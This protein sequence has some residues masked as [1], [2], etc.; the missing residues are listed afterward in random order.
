MILCN[1]IRKIRKEV[2][3]A[4]SRGMTIGLVPT[5][6]F[7]HEGHLH[8]VDMIRQYADFVIV[9]IYVNPTQFEPNEDLDTYPRDRDGDFEKLK[10]RH[11]DAVF[12]PDDEI[13]YP[14]PYYSYV[15]VEDIANIL[16]GASRPGHFRGVTTIV[17]KL[18]NIIQP[19]FA[20]FGEKDFQQLA[21][22]EKMT[23]DLNMPVKIIGAPIM[24]ESD[25][26]A[27]S[28]RNKY[29]ND[30][31]R[32]EATILYRSLQL[33]K[34]IFEKGETETKTIMQQMRD[35]IEANSSGKI[36]YIEFFDAKT[37]TLKNKAD[38]YTRVA[39]A[40]YFGKTRLIDNTPIKTKDRHE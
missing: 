40:V 13:M 29:L 11:V 22:I 19:G 20:V 15:V 36:D 9:S 10:K 34:N 23:T 37:L 2:D 39:L 3:K 27:M 17:T 8:L 38:D 4:K 31:H 5:M 32:R 16:C 18:F 24:R 6:G 7:L 12:F 35:L 1:T 33:A 25:G 28:S 30:Q 14:S 26:L 21:I